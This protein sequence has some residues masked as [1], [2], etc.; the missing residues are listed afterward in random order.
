[1]IKTDSDGEIV[2]QHEFDVAEFETA[3]F[4]SAAVLPDGG[5]VFVGQVTRSGEKYWDMLWLTLAPEEPVAQPPPNAPVQG[6]I[7]VDTADQVARLSTFGGHSDKVIDLVFSGDGAYLASSSLDRTI[8]VWDIASWQEAHAFPMN[9]VG[10]NGIAL[11]PDG[12]LLASADAIWDLQSKGIIHELE[13]NRRDPAP[14]AF[15]PD[16]SLLAVAVEGQPIKL[17][18]VATGGV[19]RTFAETLDEVTFRIVFSPG[20]T[21]LAVGA[22][23]GTVRLWDVESGEVAGTIQYGHGD[24]HDADFSPD[25]RA[26]ATGGT[27]ETVRLWDVASGQLVHTMRQGNG[28]YGVAVS[29]DGTLVASAGCDRTVKL[30]DAASGQLVRSLP[31]ADEVMTVA[32]SPD[33]SLLA[34]GGYDDLIYLWGIP[35]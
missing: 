22:H 35:P 4:S 6:A 10:F 13:R 21:L 16:G 3:S 28:L 27:D 29:P 30:W 2:W 1:V 26:L 8:K 34:S 18:D 25:G 17:W 20:G 32:F 15:S 11:S 23:E 5:Y 19:A 9:K 24:V 12:R 7:S 31:H 14:V 33:G